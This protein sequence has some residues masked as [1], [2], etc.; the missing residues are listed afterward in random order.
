[1]RRAGTLSAF[2]LLAVCLPLAASAGHTV[3]HRGPHGRTVVHKGPR[4]RVVVHQGF[5]IRR[6]L[7]EVYV[8][9]PHVAVRVAPRVYLHPLAF[10]GVVVRVRPARVAWHEAERIERAE[11][12]AD[13]TYNVAHAGSHLYFEVADGPA[14]VSFA[15]IVYGNGETQVVDFAD[16]VYA[17]GYYGLLDFDA[18]RGIDHV[19]LIASADGDAAS[20]AFH[21]TP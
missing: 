16:K 21:L 2:V 17:P 11:E 9:A 7:P 6:T 10:P 8:R 14:R 1:M 13:V 19:R 3:V 4:G 15:E 18:A 12:W 20:I 5:P